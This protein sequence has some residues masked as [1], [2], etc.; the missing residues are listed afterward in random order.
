MIP[1]DYAPPLPGY[2]WL[3]LNQRN[4]D[5]S[6][7]PLASSIPDLIIH[8]GISLPVPI[9]FE[10]RSGTAMGW[11]EWVDNELFDVG[12][13]GLLQRADVLKAIVSPLSPTVVYHH[14]YLLLL[15]RRTHHYP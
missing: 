6:W 5:V 14:S 15:L 7:A 3:A 12:F 11:R 9:H 10:F 4:S 8:Q 13:M 2:V 1:S